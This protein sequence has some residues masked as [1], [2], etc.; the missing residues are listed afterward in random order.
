MTGIKR[1]I[2]ILCDLVKE[3]YGTRAEDGRY[4]GTSSI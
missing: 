4:R 1:V 3:E 2:R